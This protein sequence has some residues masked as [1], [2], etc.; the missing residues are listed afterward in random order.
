MAKISELCPILV[1]FGEFG[2]TLVNFGE[3]WWTLV[4]F[5]EL[6]V[7]VGALFRAVKKVVNFPNSTL[8]Y[9]ITPNNRLNCTKKVLTAFGSNFTC[10]SGSRLI[11]RPA[12]RKVL[13]NWGLIG[14]IVKCWEST[15]MCGGFS[16]LYSLLEFNKANLPSIVWIWKNVRNH[17][18]KYGKV[19]D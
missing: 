9:K 1:I 14:S 3:P 11:K 2:C 6:W 4:N 19:S 7:L 5:G 12:L 15:S 18:D 13:W 8:T 17:Y 10:E 16:A